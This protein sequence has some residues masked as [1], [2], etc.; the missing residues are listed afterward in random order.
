MSWVRIA[1]WIG[2]PK[3]GE[4]DHLRRITDE[5]LIPGLRVLPGVREARALWPQRREDDPP[6][7]F[8]EVIVEFDDRDALDRMLASPE[9][10]AMRE[11]VMDLAGRFDGRISHIDFEVG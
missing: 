3:A 1:Y 10:R 5:A 6:E 7:L 9:R 4:D 2:R 8:C 11:Q